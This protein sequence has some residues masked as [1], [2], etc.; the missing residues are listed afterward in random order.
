MSEDWGLVT[1]PSGAFYRMQRCLSIRCMN[2]GWI[3]WGVS[4]AHL[5]REVNGMRSSAAGLLTR[6]STYKP[7]T[8]CW[9]SAERAESWTET[10]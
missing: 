4:D 9:M 1:L 2:V 6:S 10:G 5:Q 3:V 7:L 8:G